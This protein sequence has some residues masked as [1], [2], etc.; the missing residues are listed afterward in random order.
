MGKN[1][2]EVRAQTEARMKRRVECGHLPAQGPTSLAAGGG[3]GTGGRELRRGGK[4]RVRW[5]KCLGPGLERL[6]WLVVG[7]VGICSV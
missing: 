2:A 3:A 6:E 4:A 5:E 1:R 7:R